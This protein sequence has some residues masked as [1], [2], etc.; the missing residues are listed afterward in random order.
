MFALKEKLSAASR[1]QALAPETAAASD[2]VAAS[3]EEQESMALVSFP[4]PDYDTAMYY[5]RDM[6]WE[7][8]LPIRQ[9]TSRAQKKTLVYDFAKM[10]S[11]VLG[12]DALEKPFLDHPALV[13]TDIDTSELTAWLRDSVGDAALAAA[14]EEQC[15]EEDSKY[16]KTSVARRLIYGRYQQYRETIAARETLDESGEEDCVEDGAA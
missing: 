3:S 11:Y 16:G 7:D 10:A 6:G 2:D 5:L 14:M 8:R 13:L 1:S 12:K 15:G 9:V 4:A